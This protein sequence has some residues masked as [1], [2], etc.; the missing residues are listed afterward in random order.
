ML[1]TTLI[2]TVFGKT[3][4]AEPTFTVLATH[5]SFQ[6][7]SYSQRFAIGTTCTSDNSGFRALAGFIGVGSTPK[8]SENESI[9]MTAPVIK[10]QASG[11]QFVLP[12]KFDDISKIPSPTDSDVKIITL[13]AQTGA[14][15]TFSGWVSPSQAQQ[16]KLNLYDAL[17]PAGIEL[18]EGNQWQLW[19][20]NPPFTIPWLRRNEIWVEL[21]E[22]EVEKAV[23]YCE[24]KM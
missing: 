1:L 12:A 16:Q 9:A 17:S 10:D 13:P 11:M 18:N 5:E 6:V 3:G 7:R 4:V 23:R 24:G 22:E 15:S 2:V 21:K 14:V 8:N 20:Y 19:Q